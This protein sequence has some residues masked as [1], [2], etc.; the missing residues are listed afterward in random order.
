MTLRRAAA[1]VGLLFACL[2]AL[3]I[4]NGFY[5]SDGE[6]MFQTTAALVERHAF[7]L[8]RDPGLP[9]IVP[10]QAG[11][12][13]SKYDPG[14]SLLMVPFYVAGDW[15]AAINAAH[16][17]RVAAIAVLFVP[18]LAAGLALAGSVWA[19][20][21][22]VPDV[23]LRAALRIALAAGLASPLWWYGRTLFAEAVLACALAWSAALLVARPGRDG[24]VAWHV[25]LAGIVA[26]LG[27][28]TRAAFGVY[29]P[30]L[31]WLSGS[32]TSGRQRAGR[33]AVFALGTVPGLAIVLAHNALRFGDPLASGYAGEGFT[34]PAWKGVAGLLVSPGKGIAWHAPPLL[35]G[36]ML[37]PRLRRVAPRLAWFLVLAWV[38][39]LLVFGTWW[40]WDGGWSWGPRFLVPLIPLSLLPL[41]VLPDRAAWRIAFGVL[42][43][44]GVLVNLPALLVDITP[45]YAQI[46]ETAAGVDRVNWQVRDAL[47]V[48]AWER[49]LHGHTEPLA[50]FRLR[51]AGLPPAWYAGLPLL[52]G[53]G[54]GAGMWLIRRAVLASERVA[55]AGPPKSPS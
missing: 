34:T 28:A 40:A 35:L 51:D 39:A 5:S 52:L 18:A 44:A 16:R 22:G 48:A 30:A 12:W 15:V 54:C 29:I 13:Y 2:Y 36:V 55:H 26:G 7:A 6:V 32:S 25:L 50:L 49:L 9:Q 31:V 3:S 10:G 47:P 45:H 43:L 11:A 21:H 20:L 38:P 19:G 46:A 33:W 17:Y 8:A 53:I 1:G 41:V 42:V 27:I 23:A 14:L 4:A 37:W 24:S